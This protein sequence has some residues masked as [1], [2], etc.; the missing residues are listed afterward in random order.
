MSIT[1]PIEK[2]TLSNRFMVLLFGVFVL[3]ALGFGL[4]YFWD[5]Q[6]GEFSGYLLL[7][8]LFG[9]YLVPYVLNFRKIRFFW[10]LLGVMFLIFLSPMYINIFII[11][12]MANLHDVSWGSRDTDSKKG[13]ETRKNL[14]KF[15]ALS[16]IVWIFLNS[17]YAYGIIYISEDNGDIYIIVLTVLVSGSVILRLLMAIV[18][19]FYDLYSQCKLK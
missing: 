12:S 13:D 19:R 1:K 11:Y 16:L 14:E 7:I 2:S 10:Y 15:R 3:A 8:T 17:A 5:E 18:H 4:K 6:K 9:S